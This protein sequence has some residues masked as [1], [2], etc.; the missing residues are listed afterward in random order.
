NFVMLAVGLPLT[1][2]LHPGHRSLVW[3]W[4][5][6]LT[7]AIMAL[8][9]SPTALWMF[10]HGQTTGGVSTD[11]LS[12]VDDP[13]GIEVIIQGGSA[14]LTS[15]ALFPMPFV[16]V[17]L[18]VF[19]KTFL[20][21]RHEAPAQKAVHSTSSFLAWLM[22]V[23]LGLH[24]LL[25]V[26]FGAVNFTERWM[27]PALMVLPI[28]LFARLSP[29]RPSGRTI[30]FYL[31]VIAIFVAVAAGAR[32]YR[33]AEGADECGKC[34]EF[35]PFAALAADLRAA[36][37][38]SG[39]IIADGMHIGGNLKMAF[40]ESRVIDA[41]F[42]LAL[43][44]SRDD[45]DDDGKGMC[46]M[47]WRDD[48]ADATARRAAVLRFASDQLNVPASLN[49]DSGRIEAMLLNSST[50]RYALGF[51]LIRENAGGCR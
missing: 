2:L 44:P 34:R 5:S 10:S 39:T 19:G 43:W 27:H 28:Y 47:V 18:A 32:L 38:K 20:R 6:L 35:A 51:E 7:I 49:R 22:V 4:K 14:I 13:G 16:L 25:I 1:C 12:G 50:R 24:V 11:I 3:H 23:I 29:R 30:A 9:V 42:P 17:F 40:P 33:Y 41:A 46:L 36:G 26:F 31:G 8:I 21:Q 45:V 15:L 48:Q 37:F